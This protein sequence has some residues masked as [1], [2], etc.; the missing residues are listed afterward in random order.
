MSEKDKKLLALAG[1][2]AGIV[3]KIKMTFRFC[4]GILGQAPDSRVGRKEIHCTT[5]EG[6]RVPL[7]LPYGGIIVVSDSL[8]RRE[9]C[10][11]KDGMPDSWLV[12][13]GLK[14]EGVLLSFDAFAG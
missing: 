9:V 13:C 6:T 14:K 12:T 3:G 8:I 2:P 4:P 5:Y 1:L 10:S 11:T 7:Y